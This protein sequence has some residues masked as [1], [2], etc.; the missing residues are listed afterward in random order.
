MAKTIANV[1]V[2]EATLYVRR[3]ND[4]LA[5]W[6]TEHAQAGTHSA[7]LYKG[8]SGDAGSTHLQITPPTGITLANWTTGAAAGHYTWYY[9]YEALTANW[10]Q[11][12]FRFED[13]TDGSEGWVEIT[14]VPHQTHLGTAGWL[15]Y[16]LAT[17]P[18]VGFGGWGELGI[19]AAFFDWDLGDTVST[20]EATINALGVVDNASDWILT[21]VRFELWEA[22]PARSA[23]IDTVVINNVAYTIEPGGT[24]PAMVLSSPYT[25]VGY[26]DDGVTMEYTVEETDIM[27]HE[28]T[29]P[30]DSAIAREGITVTCNMAEASLANINQAMAG[31]VLSGS[32]LTLG[33]GVNKTMNL[34]IEGTNPDGYLRAIQFPKVV[35][36][37]TVGMS[38]KKDDKTIVPVTFKA[39]KAQ[40]EQVCTIVDNAA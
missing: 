23:W 12:E 3:P 9:W 31:A 16:D 22:E 2:G 30:V 38:Y 29:F 24:A 17:D 18:V 26:T 25:E 40:D 27:V 39:L 34:K 36:S 32:K 20:V 19:G 4:A 33:D 11:A 7:K 37:G 8:G 1:L 6:S 28:E 21:R 5:E 15:Q 10:V 14:C 35:A 13:P